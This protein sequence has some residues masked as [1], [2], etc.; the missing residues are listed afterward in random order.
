MRNW[1]P[2]FETCS[3][4]TVKLA[5]S[6][7]CASAGRSTKARIAS[8]VLMESSAVCSAELRF[9][10]LAGLDQ[11]FHGVRR[12]HQCRAFLGGQLQLDDALDAVLAD[13]RRH[14]DIKILDSV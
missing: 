12:F 9:E 5:V 4:L 10:F 1:P 11:A 3:T 14:A 7:A 2:L 13:H 6:S 8:E